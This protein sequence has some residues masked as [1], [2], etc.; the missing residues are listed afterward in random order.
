MGDYHQLTNL[1]DESADPERLKDVRA[2]LVTLSAAL[3]AEESRS[4]R[5]NNGPARQ[6]S[7]QHPHHHDGGFERQPGWRA[8]LHTAIERPAVQL[9]LAALLAIDLFSIFAELFLEAEHPTCGKIKANV[10]CGAPP[11]AHAGG[12]GGLEH[13]MVA[14]PV[15]GH[16]GAAAPCPATW[17]DGGAC[18][19]T[20]A[21][22]GVA[23]VPPAPALHT[24][25]TALFFATVA[26]LG[27]FELELLLLVVALGPARF[28]TH[29]LYVVDFV[30]VNASIALEWRLHDDSNDDG[31]AAVGLLVLVR[32][33]RFVRIGHGILETKHKKDEASDH[34][35]HG[36]GH[37]GHGGRGAGGEG[38]AGGGGVAR[39]RHA[40]EAAVAA[41]DAALAGT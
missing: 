26:I 34:H 20:L 36:H 2:S 31:S 14:G 25:H 39:A 30:V 23:C 40:V 33:W 10:C 17:G 3:A 35:G 24:A 16:H 22:L 8:R 15:A 9:L 29:A 7:I 1:L 21:R 11:H 27:V 19:A 32:V 41:L 37:G 5:G 13:L 12:G 38:G 28:F 4:S 18:A 6:G